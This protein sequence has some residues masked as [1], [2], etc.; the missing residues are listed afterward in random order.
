MGNRTIEETK[1][2]ICYCLD[3][4]IAAADT[5]RNPRGQILCLF[6]LSGTPS[7]SEWSLS[8]PS[9]S[10][11]CQH[12]NSSRVVLPEAALPG[13]EG[14]IECWVGACRSAHQ[15]PGRQGSA[16]GVRAPA[17]PL[18]GAPA[19]S[20][21]PQCALHLLGSV[22]H[23]EALSGVESATRP[24]KAMC[25]VHVRQAGRQGGQ[26]CLCRAYESGS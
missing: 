14:S 8:Q 16:G 22:A 25:T 3:N 6:D 12:A 19:R 5:S 24:V 21:V 13:P 7:S 26:L 17:V 18:P 10:I 2:F 1:R 20:V 9:P 23:G 15:E 11:G 4:T